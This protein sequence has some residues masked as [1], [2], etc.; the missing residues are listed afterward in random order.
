MLAVG[1]AS[2][3]TTQSGVYCVQDRSGLRIFAERVLPD[4]GLAFGISVWSKAKNNIGVFGIAPSRGD[5][6]E[7]TE[8]LDSQSPA[9]RCRI[10]FS[11]GSNKVAHLAADPMANCQSRGGRGTEIGTVQ[12]SRKAYEGPVTH[13]LDDPEAFFGKA[14]KCWRK[15]NSGSS[16]QAHSHSH[17]R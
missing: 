13:E 12:F 4:G 8:N 16:G 7:Y 11:L 5:H 9:D 3:E 15:Q 14:G 10:T 6:W 2:A 17:S 1:T